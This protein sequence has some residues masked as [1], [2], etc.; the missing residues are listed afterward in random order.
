MCELCTVYASIIFVG[1]A[2][3]DVI[4]SQAQAAIAE[5]LFAGGAAFAVVRLTRYLRASE[6]VFC[7]SCALLY[8]STIFLETRLPCRY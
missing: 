6:L 7:V 1:R 5:L 2:C 8:A 3:L 4:E